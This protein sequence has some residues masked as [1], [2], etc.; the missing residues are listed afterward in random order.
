MSKDIFQEAYNKY[1]ETDWDYIDPNSE[2]YDMIIKNRN[3]HIFQK[4]IE[5]G[6]VEIWDT[7]AISSID[8]VTKRNN[9]TPQHDK[10]PSVE[11]K[12]GKATG[13]IARVV[14]VVLAVYAA[15]SIMAA[16]PYIFNYSIFTQFIL[17]VL[18]LVA[19]ILLFRKRT[20]ARGGFAV[21]VMLIYISV[22]ISGSAPTTITNHL[23]GQAIAIS[24]GIS[25]ILNLLIPSLISLILPVIW[26]KSK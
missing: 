8:A 18:Y 23:T 15:F 12:K 24:V 3:A 1:A 20:I 22:V 11:E 7:S 19:F 14:A 4:M 16:V 21:I 2:Y 13:K 9:Q 26:P 25:K 10:Y 6:E 17:L 5:N